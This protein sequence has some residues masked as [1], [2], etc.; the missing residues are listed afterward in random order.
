MGLRH[1]SRAP[2]Q[3]GS[4]K[5]DR[6]GWAPVSSRGGHRAPWI[7]AD[8]LTETCRAPAEIPDPS[9]PFDPVGSLTPEG[10]ANRLV[11]PSSSELKGRV[12]GAA[13]L[14]LVS[15]ASRLSTGCI[16]I[17]RPPAALVCAAKA[18]RHTGPLGAN[19]RRARFRRWHGNAPP[20]TTHIR[21]LTAQW[22]IPNWYATR[23]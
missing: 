9:V 3:K 10:A 17:V 23:T 18:T 7:R 20:A 6:D 1:R 13:A 16:C 5:R 8:I 4:R 15:G 22:L 14:G 12:S 19:A 2:R 11:A 21:E